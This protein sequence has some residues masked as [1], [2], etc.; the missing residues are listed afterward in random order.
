MK[1][2]LP[3][4]LLALITVTSLNAQPGTSAKNPVEYTTFLR[5]QPG[6]KVNAFYSCMW[7]N[8]KNEFRR[9]VIENE[10][11]KYSVITPQG[12]KDNL[13][14]EQ[15]LAYTTSSR[16]DE[17]DPHKPPKAT[18]YAGSKLVTVNANG[19]HTIV[20]GNKRYGPYDEILF[21]QEMGQ[22][23]IAVG[24]NLNNGKPESWYVDSEGKKKLLPA[25]PMQ[26][27][28]N[29]DLS[30]A[31]IIMP[32]AESIPTEI[33]NTWPTE[34][35]Y[36]Y[37]DSLAKKKEVIW[38]NN[39]SM[40]AITRKYRR[41]EYDASGRHFVQVYVGHFLID[42]IRMDKDISGAGTRLFVGK[43]PANWV[44][45]FQ[46]YLGFS[47]KGTFKD[48]INPFLSTENGKD[49]LNW[50]VVE[51]GKSGDIVKMGKKEL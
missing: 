29:H 3:V 4:F 43:D 21:I 5:L 30:K 50:F 33:V 17:F 15:M 34:K 49:Y 18:R 20:S 40:G 47:D 32:P 9:L 48:V 1:K 8:E 38:F 7:L 16:C 41:L 45:W 11:K 13:S 26:F 6:E 10:G 24:K 27:I 28:V 46:V 25:Q 12:R 42:G 37:Y 23:F 31:A 22:T 14:T 51:P 2:H 44:Y 36:A 39:D 35:R 19:K